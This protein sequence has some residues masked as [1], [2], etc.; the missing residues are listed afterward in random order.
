MDR[1]KKKLMK[2]VIN[3]MLQIKTITT[4]WKINQKYDG[5]KECNVGLLIQTSTTQRMLCLGQ[6]YGQ[7]FVLYKD[8]TLAN[9]DVYTYALYIHEKKIIACIKT[10]LQQYIICIIV[11]NYFA[12]LNFFIFLFFCKTKANTSFGHKHIRNRM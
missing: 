2:H 8:N 12:T 1:Y 3:Q 5:C 7:L 6:K 4:F 11:K 10:W 9:F